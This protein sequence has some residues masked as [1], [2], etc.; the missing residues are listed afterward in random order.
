M[1]WKDIKVQPA[2]AWELLLVYNAGDKRPRLAHCLLYEGGRT[3]WY[4]RE[5]GEV[6]QPDFW[7]KLSTPD[8]KDF[9]F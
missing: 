7:C 1:V 9:D 4:E 2:P 3:V 5:V 6:P 8:G